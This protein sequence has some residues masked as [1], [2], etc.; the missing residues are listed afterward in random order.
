MAGR[1]IAPIFLAFLLS[2]GG[3]AEAE[4]QQTDDICKGLFEAYIARQAK[5]SRKTIL[6]A[7]Q[8]VTERGRV[9]GFWKNILAELKRDREQ[10]EIGCVQVL[11][12][13]LAKDAT[14]RDIFRRQKETGEI[15]AMV[16]YVCLSPEVVAE[17]IERGQ[18]AD[19]FRVDHYAIA[20][21]RARVPETRDFLESMLRK[22][23]GRA[24]TG[25]D[26]QDRNVSVLTGW[27][28]LDST[29]FHAAVGLAQLGD[30]AGIDWLIANSEYGQGTVSNACPRGVTNNSSLSTCCVAA[31][32][33]LSR[34]RN[35]I[36][37][38]RNLKGKSQWKAWA[39]TVDRK[40]LLNNE[41]TLVDW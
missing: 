23:T 4:N 7:S 20:L 28:Y 27:Y 11:G 10:S 41:I 35:L 31:L 18:K 33:Q 24:E 2:L 25:G 36:P 32:R 26:H 1:Y 39:K 13:M 6:A 8:I 34:E 5:T 9:T 30:P 22:T 29:R 16:S 38:G 15:N 21:A 17:L 3:I 19:R 12:K 40:T 14:A 37:R